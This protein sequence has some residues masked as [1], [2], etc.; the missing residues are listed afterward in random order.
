MKGTFVRRHHAL[1]AI[2]VVAIAIVA[3]MSVA[4]WGSKSKA[5]ASSAGTFRGDYTATVTTWD[6]SASFSTEVAYMAN[7][8]EPLLYSAAPGSIKE[9]WPGLATS[10]SRTKDGLHWTFNL[11]KKVTFHDGTAFT[12]AAV[13][14]SLERTKKLN[15]APAYLL[16][17][18]KKIVILNKYKVRFDLSYAAGLDRIL[19]GS[20][21]AWIFSPKTATWKNWD[22]SAK[23]D[24]TGP[25]VLTS[26]KPNDTIKF[27][28]YAK[29]W[30]GWKKSQFS[31]IVVKI[32]SDGTTQQQDLTSGGTDYQTM[33]NRDQVKTLKKNKNVHVYVVKT[34]YNYIMAFNCKRAPLSNVAV[35][36]ALSYAVPYK[37]IIT[38]GA[39]GYATQAKGPVPVGLWPNAK[40]KLPQYT[41]DLKKADKMLTAA[42]YPKAKRGKFNLKLTY[43]AENT[44]EKAFVPLIKGSFKKLGIKVTVNALLWNQQYSN[45]IGSPSKR[46]DL[47]VVLWWPTL[48]DGHD[49]L[50]SLFQSEKTAAWNFSYWYNKTYDKTLAKAY[51][52]SATSTKSSQKAYTTAMTQLVTQAPAAYLFDSKTVVAYLKNIKIAW[53]AGNAN[54]PT[55][56]FWKYVGK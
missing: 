3:I 8:Y 55:V 44:F 4:A 15:F 41:Y 48:P 51:K 7:M 24:G 37:S 31:N 12:A 38:V 20:S 10:W 45:A 27:K 17:P 5:T 46:Q 16:A 21:A 32:V 29:W 14:Y 1:S 43:A 23:E 50:I 25:W 33:V 56:L 6:P 19:A 40:G 34:W 35:R 53:G 13:K 22:S 18:I 2:F 28:R 49:N 54:Y 26:Y 42:G 47:F 36:K 39:G 11:R 30:G 52:L 9:F